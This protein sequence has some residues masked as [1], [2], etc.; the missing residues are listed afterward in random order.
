[1]HLEI[2]RRVQA[3]WRAFVLPVEGVDVVGWQ[4]SGDGICT[5]IRVSLS[6]LVLVRVRRDR[7]EKKRL[8]EG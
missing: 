2:V 1:L 7:M 5:S 6:V 3:H 4:L 8:R